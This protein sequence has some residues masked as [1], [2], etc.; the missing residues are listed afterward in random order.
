MTFDGVTLEALLGD[1]S[2]AAPVEWEKRILMSE[3]PEQDAR[4][5]MSGNWRLVNGQELYHVELDPKQ[6]ANLSAD[7][8]KQ[9]ERMQK[10]AEA[11]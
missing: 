2:D 7:Y 9:V 3:A 5:I 1:A 11:K 6:L 4:C 8:P 10:F